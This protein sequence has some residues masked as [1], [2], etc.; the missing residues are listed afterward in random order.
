MEREALE[1]LL[2]QKLSVE[3]IAKRFGKDPSTVS[4][5]MGKYGLEAVNRKKHAS[6][7][8]LDRAALEELVGAGLTI[9]EIGAAVKKSKGTVRYWLRRYG[10][11]TK[12]RRGVRSL[13]AVLDAKQQGRLT[14]RLSCARHGEAEFFLEGRGYYRCKRCRA[15]AVTRRR[16]KVK[17]T[18]VEEAG[19]CCAICGYNRCPSAL[20]FHHLDPIHK[21]L[22]V[23][24][25]GVA[26]AIATL[27][28]EVRKCTLLCANCHAEVESGIAVVPARVPL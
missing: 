13:Q 20:A 4:Y 15:D 7:G 12:N 11:Q 19:G 16:R 22:E 28:E 1:S 26:V 2:A 10:L 6:K 9:A 3:R 18:L 27:R 23:N 25:R 5:W 8:G 24:A 17:A 21:R 14:V